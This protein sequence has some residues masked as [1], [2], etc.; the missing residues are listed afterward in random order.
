M[1][2]QV[3]DLR[4]DA[5]AGPSG[6]A[7]VD[8]LLASLGYVGTGASPAAGTDLADPKDR[9][10]TYRKFQEAAYALAQGKPEVALP[11]LQSLAA[12]ED[13]PG[14]HFRLATAWRMSGRL[15]DAAREL[16]RVQ[17]V[18]PEFPGIHMERTR[19]ALAPPSPDPARG[20]R[21]VELHLA[22]APRDAG[23]LMFRGAAKEMLGDL[24]GAE[25][26]YRAA[27]DFNPLF[28]GAALRL[29]ALLVQSGREVEAR[30][31]LQERL[32]VEPG[33]TLARGLL[34]SL[35]S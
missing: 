18:Q 13:T 9:L 1:I 16:D 2:E 14:V 17:A 8:P 5:A 6:A 35:S 3:G 31:V 33:D 23:A 11:I 10:E 12:A 22:Q 15:K 21:E 24:A 32:R 34:N 7:P 27:L 4:R 26:D 29:A 20:L 19:L 28:G 25:A 30:A